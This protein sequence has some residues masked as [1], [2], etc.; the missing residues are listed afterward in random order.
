MS[1]RS[2]RLLALYYFVAHFVAVMKCAPACSGWAPGRRMLL[3][4]VATAVFALRLPLSLIHIS[5]P[6]R[7]ALI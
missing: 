7:L 1:C 2:V 4:P 6:T 5:E 3:W